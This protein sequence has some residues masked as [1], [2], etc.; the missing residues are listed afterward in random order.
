MVRAHGLESSAA[1]IV[2]YLPKFTGYIILLSV[3]AVSRFVEPGL[4][5]SSCPPPGVRYCLML[6]SSSKSLWFSLAGSNMDSD[7]KESK[8]QVNLR[9]KEL[10][11][12]FSAWVSQ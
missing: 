2:F 9:E 3:C 1:I 4:S 6:D 10:A 5:S 11:Q 8:K 12:R 7:C